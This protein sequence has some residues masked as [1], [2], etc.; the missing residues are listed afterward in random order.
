[1][2]E[3]LQNGDTGAAGHLSAWLSRRTAITFRE[4]VTPP[5]T[6]PTS[7]DAEPTPV[8]PPAVAVL[9]HISEARGG[10]EPAPITA[11]G[12]ADSSSEPIGDVDAPNSRKLAPTEPSPAPLASMFL[13]EENSLEIFVDLS[14]E[15]RGS[16]VLPRTEQ[17]PPSPE[18]LPLLLTVPKADLGGW[19][20]Q[21][22]PPGSKRETKS[23]KDEKKADVFSFAK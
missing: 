13:P 18:D 7:T 16:S 22:P 2:H 5:A 20:G 10:A 11:V 14:T 21:E 3:A 23:R 19:K 8:V 15:G 12:R 1:M 9:G 17:P 4:E 6:M